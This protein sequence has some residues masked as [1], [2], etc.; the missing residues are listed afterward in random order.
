MYIKI[1]PNYLD[2]YD[3]K[4]LSSKYQMLNQSL[5]PQNTSSYT[6]PVMGTTR[7]EYSVENT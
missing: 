4:A 1:N 6:I 5:S 7:K 2:S 3:Y